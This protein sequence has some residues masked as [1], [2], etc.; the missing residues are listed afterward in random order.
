VS[1][2]NT[3][4][5][6]NNGV[7]TLKGEAN[8]QAQKDLTGEYAKDI[9]G[10]KGVNNEMTIAKVENKA[11]ETTGDKIDDASIKAQ[12]KM[13]FLM[14]HSTSAFKTEV[15]V[16]N[17]VVTLNGDTSS[18]AGKDMATKVANDINGVTKVVNNMTIIAPKI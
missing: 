3:Q 11:Q 15:N 8:S 2:A 9:E 10:I 18:G 5:I 12:V 6:V 14:H 4:V 1:A 17:G 7:V 16:E 13:A